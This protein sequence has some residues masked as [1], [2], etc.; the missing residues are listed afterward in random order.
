MTCFRLT[1]VNHFNIEPFIQQ[2]ILL[3]SVS[4]NERQF[5][6]QE[7]CLFQSECAPPQSLPRHSWFGHQS[8]NY[9]R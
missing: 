8:E 4:G 2:A 9:R 1:L 7:T 3:S 6:N 5:S